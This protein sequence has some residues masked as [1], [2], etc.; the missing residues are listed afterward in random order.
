MGKWE[1]TVSYAI[2][3]LPI[4]WEKER[5]ENKEGFEAGCWERDGYMAVE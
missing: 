1:E 2:F 3:F 4:S 5:R